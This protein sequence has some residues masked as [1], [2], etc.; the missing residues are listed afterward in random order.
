MRKILIGKGI[1]EYRELKKSDFVIHSVYRDVYAYKF[2]GEW[3]FFVGCQMA[4][5]KEEFIDKIYN[6][7]GGLEENPHRQHYLDFLAAI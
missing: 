5:S 6:E 2:Q 4:I 1:L 7:D 3:Y